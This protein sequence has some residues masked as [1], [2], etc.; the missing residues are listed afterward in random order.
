MSSSETCNTCRDELVALVYDELDAD[1]RQV[2]LAHIDGCADCTARLEAYRGVRDR[3]GDWADEGAQTVPTGESGETDPGKAAHTKSAPQPLRRFSGLSFA[4]G[5]AAALV[6]L[7]IGRGWIMTDGISQPIGDR[8]VLLLREGEYD[9]SNMTPEI[10]RGRVAEYMNWSNEW[11]AKGNP[12]SGEK[13]TD[14]AIRFGPGANEGIDPSL[15]LSGF[16]VFAADSQTE[17]EAVAK[18]CPHLK[19]GGAIELRQVDAIVADV[20]SGG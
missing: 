13:L 8:Y 11:D 3:L 6:L 7:W 4:A 15:T 19:Y 14:E 1:K 18:S 9:Y 2:V 5:L 20:A 16:F 10:M 12:M 17:A